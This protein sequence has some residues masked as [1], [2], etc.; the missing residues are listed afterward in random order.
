MLLI[1]AMLLRDQSRVIYDRCQRSLDIVRHIRD[2]LGLHP[3]ALRA[4]L[5]RDTHALRD[6]VQVFT[7]LSHSGHHARGID[8]IL[9]ITA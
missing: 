8:L 5:N 1:V 3:L 9:K 2:Q 6:R 7:G 4:L